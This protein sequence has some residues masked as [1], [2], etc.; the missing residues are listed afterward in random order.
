MRRI[1]T[2]AV[3]VVALSLAGAA[4]SKSGGS[5]LPSEPP[6]GGGSP[7]GAS[8]PSVAIPSSVT[9]GTGTTIDPSGSVPPTS[10]PGIT[11]AVNTGTAQVITT[12]DVSTQVT[13]GKLGSPA[14]WSPPPG[15]IALVWAGVSGQTFGLGGESFTAVQPTSEARSLA[16][17]LR[18]NNVKV[19]FRS[20]AGECT[21]TISP[22]LPNNVGGTFQC[23]NL[24]SVDGTLTINAQG[25]FSAV[26]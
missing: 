22:A 9:G 4:C 10:S 23:A 5:E 21:V 12:G 1:Q 15:A 20:V 13:F 2:I 16:L 14:V 7:A 19:A 17:T 3:A 18:L 26:G 6:T 11:G 25:S 8:S 24:D